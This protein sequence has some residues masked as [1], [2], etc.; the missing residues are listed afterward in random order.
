MLSVRSIDKQT[1]ELEFHRGDVN[2]SAIAVGAI[3][4]KTDDP[5]LRKRLEHSFARD[6]VANRTPLDAIVTA[7]T[8][9]K[10]KLRLIASDQI[11]EVESDA[12]LQVANK[13]PA[14]ESMLRE[15]IDRLGDTPFALRDL[16]CDLAG[17]PMV[18]KSVLNDLRRRA[19]EQLLKQ[20]EH[21]HEIIRPNAL[22][23]MRGSISKD[24]AAGNT[25]LHLLVRTI[26]QLDA[27]LALDADAKPATIYC[28]FE[29][30]RRYKLAVEKCN[31]AKMPVALATMRIVKPHEDGWLQQILDCQPDAILVRNLASLAF[32]RER[33]P[34]LPLIGDYAL[35]IA[36]ELTAANFAEQNLLRMVPSYDLNWRQLSAMLS[37]SNPAQ[38]ECVIHQHMP[39][40]HMEH[41]VFAHTLSTGK[42]Y[43]DCGRPCE[44]HQVDLKDRVGQPH[45]L[46]P[47]AG[48]RNTVF[49]A[50]AQ[51]A[52][53][54]VPK[55]CALGIRHFR[56][57]LLRESREETGPLV[58][59]YAELLAGKTPPQQAIRSLRVLNQLGVTRGTLDR[60]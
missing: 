9:Q 6:I 25:V 35:N 14:N 24:V 7:R 18:P 16:A 8:G 29:D 53:E 41:C 38:F 22:A 32:Y 45:P 21:A 12:P 39:M 46:I 54:F 43:R 60:E 37:R 17:D 10:L 11:A 23:E 5:A 28:D 52:A 42:D 36:N 20:R 48:C 40:F 27:V 59:R 30:V 2:L 13:H 56:V 4:W 3:V 31:A 47:D 15:Q 1:L 19:V 49:N 50:Q 26:D 55:M 33:A 51:S 58:R 34:S 57:E 44:T